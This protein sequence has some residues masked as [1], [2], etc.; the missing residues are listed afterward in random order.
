[1]EQYLLRSGRSPREGYDNARSYECIKEI[2]KGADSLEDTEALAFVA[3]EL[4]E[5][6]LWKRR[7]GDYFGGDGLEMYE[8]I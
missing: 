2:T 8:V 3:E 1:M 5:L 7:K 4:R 6:W